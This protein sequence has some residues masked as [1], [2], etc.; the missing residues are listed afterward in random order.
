[1]QT[2][3]MERRA[4]RALRI[5]SRVK[6]GGCR[7]ALSSTIRTDIK[8]KKKRKEARP[9]SSLPNQHKEQLLP[10]TPQTPSQAP[11]PLWQPTAPTPDTPPP[12]P[13]LWGASPSSHTGPPS[14]AQ[15]G[16]KYLSPQGLCTGCCSCLDPFLPSPSVVPSWSVSRSREGLSA[17]GGHIPLPQHPLPLQTPTRVV[18]P[19]LFV[20]A[21]VCLV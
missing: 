19:S 15:T 16:T 18:I 21:S 2:R 7:G 20:L 5:Q 13:L 12:P 1:M 8:G 17:L 14:S 10:R 4:G 11:G 9:A 3:S 6:A